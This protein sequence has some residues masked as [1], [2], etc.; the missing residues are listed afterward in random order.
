MASK[1]TLFW[2]LVRR[3]HVGGFE[4]MRVTTEKNRQ[5]FGSINDEATHVRKDA[6]VGRFETAEAAVAV[7]DRVVATRAHHEP[8]I[9]EAKKQYLAAQNA[10]RLAIEAIVTERKELTA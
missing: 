9:Q 4:V 8:F 5:F 10:E 1:S 3:W 6:T 2:T 7:V